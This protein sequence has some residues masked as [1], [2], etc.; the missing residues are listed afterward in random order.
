MNIA[1][2]VYMYCFSHFVFI[3]EPFRVVPQHTHTVQSAL[4]LVLVLSA[5]NWIMVLLTEFENIIFAVTTTPSRSR[6]LMRD[7]LVYM[8]F[9]GGTP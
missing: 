7:G 6:P 8:C 3:F 1:V 5:L 2:C 4:L 9:F